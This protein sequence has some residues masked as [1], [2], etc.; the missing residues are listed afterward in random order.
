MYL[1]R[2]RVF[3]G[4]LR[5]SS[6]PRNRPVA[7]LFFIASPIV[8]AADRPMDRWIA[9]HACD[10]L[11]GRRVRWWIRQHPAVEGEVRRLYA[12]D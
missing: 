6:D 10:W 9:R 4:L 8:R 12:S 7:L 5:V 1:I 11:D 2:R 3:G